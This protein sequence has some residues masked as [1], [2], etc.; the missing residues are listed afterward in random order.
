MLGV[1]RK[2][3]LAGTVHQPPLAVIIWCGAQ[4]SPFTGEC[5]HSVLLFIFVHG[6]QKTVQRHDGLDLLWCQH[7][8]QKKT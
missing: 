3:Q 2:L 4:H 8:W 5:T 7:P 6:G 1:R